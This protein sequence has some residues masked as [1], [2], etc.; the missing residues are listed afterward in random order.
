MSL[1]GRTCLKSVSSAKNLH[2]RHSNHSK[3][4]A[5]AAASAALHGHALLA[6]ACRLRAVSTETFSKLTLRDMP[7]AESLLLMPQERRRVADHRS[8]LYRAAPEPGDLDSA[9]QVIV[10]FSKRQHSCRSRV[11]TT[12][13]LPCDL[14]QIVL[15]ALSLSP[16][17]ISVAVVATEICS[18]AA[19]ADSPTALVCVLRASLRPM[20]LR[21]LH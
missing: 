16:H 13:G 14:R 4:Y 10:S 20:L 19:A 11:A 3:R 7:G 1:F 21:V 9:R 15:H 6:P 8:V 18:R 2:T 12:C 5:F 17:K